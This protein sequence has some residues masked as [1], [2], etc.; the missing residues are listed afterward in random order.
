MVLTEE[1]QT[2]MYP[3]ATME[4]ATATTEEAF[5][6]NL[7]STRVNVPGGYPANTPPGNARGARVSAASG[8]QKIGPAIVLKVM[9][10]DKLNLT[11]NSWWNSGSTPT[12]APNPVA[13]LA[14]ALASGLAGASGGKVTGADLTASGLPTTVATSFLNT[15]SPV[16]TRP[17]AYVNWI[18]LNEQFK[19]ESTGSGYE[20]VGTS[21]TYTTHTRTNLAITKSGYLYIYVSNISNNIDVFFDNLQVSHIRGPLLEETH[22]YPFGLAMAGISS[23]AI[24]KMDNK[25]GFNGNETQNKEFSD[26]SGLELYDFNARTYDQQTGRFI[27]IDP[28]TDDGG[29]ESLSPYHFGYNNPIRYDDPDGKCPTCPPSLPAVQEIGETLTEGVRQA[30]IVTGG[31]LNGILNAVTFG[32]WPADGPMGTSG[33]AGYTD[34]DATRAQDAATYGGMSTVPLTGPKGP[35][36]A[37]EVKPVVGN[38]LTITPPIAPGAKVDVKDNASNNGGS[39]SS[40]NNSNNSPSKQS[41]VEKSTKTESVG[42]KYTKTTDVKPGKG[43]GQSRA[44]YV[45]YKNQDGKVIRTQK[46]TYDRANRFQHKKPMRGGPEGRQQN[47]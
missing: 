18:L 34:D 28:M 12:Q 7:P 29:Q 8:L 40:K 25:R 22:Y 16:T 47:D 19:F 15:H 27:Q 1:T 17:R 35:L 14:A 5:Y 13:E 21:N 9:A 3:A 33:D 2:D 36:P 30:V 6:S 23:R 38:P 43:P 4:T 42:G 32:A 24:G 26:G 45:R 46:F 44:E 11:V 10:G 41:K 39:S 37:P 20:Q 31:V